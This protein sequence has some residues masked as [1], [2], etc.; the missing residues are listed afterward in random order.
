MAEPHTKGVNFQTFMRT[1]SR[2]KGEPAVAAT[3]AAL[4]PDLAERIKDGTLL[5]GVRV[6]V[7]P[8]QLKMNLA[9]ELAFFAAASDHVD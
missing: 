6:S 5:A 2:L 3:L 1:L 9:D 7:G 4:P 8:W